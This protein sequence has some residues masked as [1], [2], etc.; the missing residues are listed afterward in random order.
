MKMKS[1][2]KTALATS[3]LLASGMA[4]AS[5]MYIDLG[6]NVYD[7]GFDG[8]TTTGVFNEFGFG[9]LL[10]TSVYDITDGTVLGSFYDTNVTADLS[11]L[12]LPTSGL[13]MDGITLVDL[14][15]PSCGAQCD[16]D[17]LNPLVP[18]L[19]SDSEGFLQTWDL[20]LEYYFEGTLLAGGPTYTD[21]Y[22]KIFFNDLLN[23][24]NDRLILEGDLTGSNVELTNL[25][26]F[27]DITFAEEGWLWI[28]DDN[29]VF[30]D[31]YTGTQSGNYS[32]LAID[33]N[34]NPPIPTPDQLLAVDTT[35]DGV[36][37]SAI[38]QTTL[39]GSA[40]AFVP[41]PSTIA[42]VGLGL[43]GFGAATRRRAKQ[44]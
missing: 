40:T 6:T 33:T 20:Q 8:D 41:E 1:L 23:D 5:D 22:I 17:S 29:G 26:L 32:Q 10:A 24:A 28:E 19:G 15:L 12:G 31:A 35:G 30:V 4:S 11:A 14:A 27:F 3:I 37:D 43:L 7:V 38:R 9:A 39:D 36:P 2:T 25:D 34:V 16:I 42:L 21:G 13:A 18:P 44:Q